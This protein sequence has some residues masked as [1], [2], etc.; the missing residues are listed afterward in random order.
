MARNRIS[1]EKGTSR[2]DFIRKA[3]D[4]ELLAEVL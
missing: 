1:E 4:D 3:I 2:S